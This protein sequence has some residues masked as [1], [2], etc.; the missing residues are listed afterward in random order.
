[1]KKV[2]SL[3]CLALILTTASFA[4]AA[5]TLHFVIMSSEDPKKEGPKYAALAEYLKAGSPGI[6]DIQL[7]VAK[8]YPEAARLFQGGEVDGMFSGSFVAG[9]FIKKEVA[10]P[11]AR[12]VLNNGATTYKAVIIAKDGTKPFAG[13]GDFR[14]KKVAYTLLASSGE[15]FVRGLLPAGEKPENI[16][17]PVPA[18]SHQIA[19]NAVQSGAADYAVVKN[20][21]WDPAKF[22]G[23]AQVGEDKG[24]NPNNTLIMSNAAAGKHGEDVRSILVKLESDTGAQA[25]EVKKL[26]GIKAFVP[27]TNTDFSHTF[28]IFEKA[29]INAKTFDFK[30]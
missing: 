23:L 14:G 17:T 1:M 30:F 22:P 28:G 4:L 29:N 20:M 19:I 7:R 6:G 11:I 2:M 26:F 12:P 25:M 9:I 13:I 5:D 21:V 27:T 18:A 24:E 3:F 10:K 15:A 8:D 16:Y